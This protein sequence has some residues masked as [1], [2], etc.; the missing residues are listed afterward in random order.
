MAFAD[1]TT[2]G[3]TG[4]TEG[5]SVLLEE[6]DNIE[7]WHIGN[8]MKFNSGKYKVMHLGI[9]Y[10]NLCCKLGVHLLEMTEEEKNLGVF[11]DLKMTE[12]SQYEAALTESTYQRRYFQ[13]KG[14]MLVLLYNALLQLSLELCMQLWS[15]LIKGH[16]LKM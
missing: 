7:C 15:L 13:E 14:K 5:V 10:K 16:K 1:G 6:L 4:S 11:V 9:T 8:R 2:L 12:N 3:G